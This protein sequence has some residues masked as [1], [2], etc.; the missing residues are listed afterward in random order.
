M[1]DTRPGTCCAFNDT[2]LLHAHACYTRKLIINAGLLWQKKCN[3]NQAQLM[4]LDEAAKA[5][6]FVWKLDM[7]PDE[8][9]ETC[10]MQ[11]AGFIGRSSLILRDVLYLPQT[12]TRANAA[13]KK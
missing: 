9:N 6:L 7:N 2:L 4:M 8:S 12:Q 3:A 1:A 10:I 13:R 11:D 5:T